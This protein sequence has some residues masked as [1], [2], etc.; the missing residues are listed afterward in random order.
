MWLFLC[1]WYV[2]T[3]ANMCAY[4]GLCTCIFPSCGCWTGFTLA[5]PPYSYLWSP[6]CVE[7]FPNKQ[8]SVTLAECPYSLTLPGEHQILQV[9][10]WFLQDSTPPD[11]N[12]KS[13]WLCLWPT[14]YKSWPLLCSVNLLEH[15]TELRLQLTLQITDLLLKDMIE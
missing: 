14:G 5:P 13:R 1:L 4:I 10:S 7:V 11:V 15:L 12:H 6:N 9:K 2:V 8:F 3:G